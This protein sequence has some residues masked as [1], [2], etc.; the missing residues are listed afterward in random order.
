MKKSSSLQVLFAAILF[1]SFISHYA[2][3]QGA[4]SNDIDWVNKLKVPTVQDVDVMR[5][6]DNVIIYQSNYMRGI[7][8]GAKDK[9][10]LYRIDLKNNQRT[11]KHVELKTGDKRRVVVKM[12]LKDNKI[13]VFSSF[14]NEDQKKYYV[15]QETINPENLELNNDVKK[16]FEVDCSQV[17]DAKIKT[18]SSDIRQDKGR[19][20]VYASFEVKGGM[21]FFASVYDSLM[22]ETAHY[23]FQRQS[24]KYIYGYG[25]DYNDNLYYIEAENSKSD[26]Q[27]PSTIYFLGKDNKTIRQQ[28]LALEDKQI[29]P[30]WDVNKKNEVVLTGLYYRPKLYSA[31]GI[32]SIIFPPYLNGSARVKALPLSTELLA[33]GLEEKDSTKLVENFRKGKEYD[34]D[35]SDRTDIKFNDD[36]E[37]T[38]TTQGYALHRSRVNSMSYNSDKYVYGDI[39]AFTWK[40]DGSPK[41]SQKINLKTELLGEA[42]LSGGYYSF[43]DENKNLNIIYTSFNSRKVFGHNIG[44]NKD[45]KT[46]LVTFGLEGEKL[47]R[48]IIEDK[49]DSE[50][51]IP[52]FSKYLGN[53]QLVITRIHSAAIPTSS[54]FSVARISLKQ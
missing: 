27:V 20:I 11:E 53:K 32:Y 28:S 44:M 46:Y 36:E 5:M 9:S 10:C 25:I 12:I 6:D 51:F 30:V 47:E 52:S 19:I 54:D 43:Y 18:A 34:G 42:S 33:K 35:L 15:F 49:K 3:S 8:G 16:I 45:A 39:Y 4:S 29:Y 31:Q 22:N 2:F 26:E 13:L 40:A 21:H 1:F 50:N 24:P 48:V 38:L 14:K 41:W 7:F 37:F 23:A 17:K